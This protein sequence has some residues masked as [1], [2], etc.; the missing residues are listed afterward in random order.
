VSTGDRSGPAPREQLT[1][2]LQDWSKG[3]KQAGDRVLAIIYAELHKLAES[4]L[5][6]ALYAGTLQPTAIVHEAYLRLVARDL[7]DW[8]SRSHFFGIASRLMR[9]II[10]DHARA[11]AAAKRG[12]GHTPLELNEAFIY[13]DANARNVV[14]LDDA[15][16]ALART[17]ERKARV[18]EL[19]YFGGLTVEE[20]AQTVGI[21]VATTV[22]EARYAQ[23]WLRREMES[24]RGG[25]TP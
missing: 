15:L 11:C 12:G 5:R 8:Q 6:R 16:Q 18:L 21:S 17:D 20:T 25:D 3:N 23:A 1:L 7:P 9:Q 24:S 22:R 4:H 10:V 14:A 19:R 13:S 2:L